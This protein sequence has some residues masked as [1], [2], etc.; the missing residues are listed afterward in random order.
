MKS[1]PPHT[2][3]IIVPDAAAGLRLDIF[4]SRIASGA[5]ADPAW[6]AQLRDMSRSRLQQL[7]GAGD[8]QLA[9]LAARPATKLKAGQTITLRVPPPVASALAPTPMN[10]D[11][12]YE[13]AD[14]LVLNKAAGVVVH[15]G[16]G[17][18][19]ATLVHGLLAHCHDLSGIGGVMRPGIVHRLDAGTSGLLVVAKHDAAHLHLARQFA[20]RTITKRYIAAVF[21]VPAPREATID[22]WYARHPTHRRRFTSRVA[23]PA[24]G[25][26]PA[27]VRRA[28]TTYR[29]LCAG[30]GLCIV[31]IL[32][33][34]GR[35]HQ[36]RVHMSDR[37]H[38]LV[39][40]PLYGGQQFARISAPHIRQ[41]AQ[42][43]ENQA[44]HAASLTFAHPATGAPMSFYAPPPRLLVDLYKSLA[45]PLANA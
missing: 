28:L 14:M 31:D 29:V 34:T 4:L 15:P 3:T 5:S 22:T 25:T 30:F 39:G 36:I 27:G 26:M 38:P 19:T 17:H 9:G 12:V 37:G 10:L 8:V 40:D 16:A 33:G 45:H 24:S 21:G 1:S 41:L 11:I 13:D 18:P 32:L 44:L 7:I 42:A 35:T 43:W 2:L 20:A 23:T 6:A